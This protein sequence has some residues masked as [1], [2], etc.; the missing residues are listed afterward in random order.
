MKEN[1]IKWLLSG[2]PSIIYQTN[3]DL[4]S[5][6]KDKLSELQNEISKNG[7][8]RQF[9]DKRDNKTGMWGE[10][11]YSPKWIST[12]YT[13]LDLKNLGLNPEQKDYIKSAGILLNGL[14]KIP[15]K[16]DGRFLDLCICGMLLN[17]CCYAKIKSEKINQIIDYI[18]E[19]Q[20]LDGGYNCRWEVDH[21]HGSFHTTINVLEG[22]KEYLENDY[23]YR[24]NKI[25]SST[26]KAHEFILMHRLFKSDKTGII[27]DKKMTMLSYPYRWHYDILRV[28][29]YFQSINM[30]YDSRM[31]D[32]LNLL[33]SKKTKE[34]CWPVQQKYPGLVH[35]DME[36]TGKPSRW[37]TLR[38][39]R[40]LKKYGTE[41]YYKIID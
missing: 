30:P 22:L 6:S 8:G 7:W 1:I 12:T 31:E 23:H 15:E 17:I 37:N 20:F 5:I 14:W 36:Q 10:G 33:L 3:R 24:K 34:N 9:L 27:I 19:K 21:D 18:L 13:L 28:L 41:E 32:G 39:L 4:I 35:F 16:K 40:V 11:L 25:I 29:D 38:V 2:D 26:Q